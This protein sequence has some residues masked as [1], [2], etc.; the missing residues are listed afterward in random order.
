MSVYSEC[1]CVCVCMKQRE[2][3]REGNRD[4]ELER[5]REGGVECAHAAT[6]CHDRFFLSSN[7]YLNLLCVK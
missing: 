2:R 1:V 4:R 5:Q 3:K 6:V 7:Y